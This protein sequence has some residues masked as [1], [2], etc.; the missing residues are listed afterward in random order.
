MRIRIRRA[1][2]DDAPALLRLIRALAK[3][4]KLPPP[5]AQ[6]EARLIRDGWGPRP[7]FEAWLAEANGEA[8]G[9]AILYFTYS[10][11][12]AKPTLY[13]EDIFVLPSARGLGIGSALFGHARRLAAARGCG[14]ME[15]CCLDWNTQAQAFYEKAGARRLDEWIYY[16]LTEDRLGEPM[17]GD[18]DA[19]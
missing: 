2:R 14:R 15:W 8:V 16:R 3:F 12:L 17:E 1:R 18:I 11:F 19:A 7:R 9:Y 5:D 6:A 13:L 10:T 4:E